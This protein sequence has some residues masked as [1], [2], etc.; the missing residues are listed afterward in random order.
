MLQTRGMVVPGNEYDSAKLWELLCQT[1]CNNRAK[2]WKLLC[3][4]IR[5]RVSSRRHCLTAVNE[6]VKQRY[7]K[8]AHCRAYRHRP[9]HGNGQ[10]L[11][12]FRTHIRREQERHHGE[13]RSQRGHD[14][15]TQAPAS[16]FMDGFQ[17]R[18]T[19]FTQFIDCVQFQDR[20]I[21][22]DTAGDDKPDG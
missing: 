17:Q 14:N 1:I 21:D 12:Q 22:Y 15:G 16:G 4:A 10:R 2:L 3:Q 5:T 18:D 7:D 8:Q 19:C 6:P 20:V 9:Y 11:L 13:N